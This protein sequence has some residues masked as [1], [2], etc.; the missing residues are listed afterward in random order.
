M[1]YN[2]HLMKV[3]WTW[4]MK[5]IRQ[6]PHPTPE[7]SCVFLLDGHKRIPYQVMVVNAGDPVNRRPLK[8]R[9]AWWAGSLTR[10]LA[11]TPLTPNT[12]SLLG[13]VFAL[14]G[15]ACFAWIGLG[16]AHASV[17][18]AAAVCIQLRLFCN[19]MDGLVAVEAGKGEP[20][21][22]LFNEAPDRL[23]DVVLL[24]GAGLAVGIQPLGLHLGWVCAVLALGTAYV[25]LLGGSLGLAQDFCGPMAKQ[26]RMFFLTLGCFLA[27]AEFLLTENQ[28]ILAGIL[29]F[30][31][32]GS[33]WTIVRRL[34]RIHRQLK[35]SA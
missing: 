25:R 9:S 13:I 20:T 11:R 18:L 31:A 8:T 24:L 27:Y 30:I 19:M 1:T 21:G 6:R 22:A 28:Y 15:G 34:S 17:F 4:W 26:H 23:E 16:G 7:Q 10:L 32:L 3:E 33:C 14:A 12:I 29:A 5:T 35:G 2:P